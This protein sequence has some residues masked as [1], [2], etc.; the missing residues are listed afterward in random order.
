MFNLQ[1][2]WAPALAM[3]LVACAARFSAHEREGTTAGSAGES[4]GLTSAAGSSSVA[5]SGEP[6]LGG[7]NAAGAGGTGTGGGT[8]TGNGGAVSGTGGTPAGTGGGR[9]WGNGGWWSGNG[10]AGAADCATL[11]QKYQ[12]T[13]EAARACDKG[14][15]DQCSPTSVAQPVDGCGCP[16]P[17]NT[18]SAA[19]DANRKAYQAYLDA[20]CEYR[21]PICDIACPPLGTADCLQLGNSGS[22]MCLVGELL[23]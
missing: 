23:K 14:S 19:A 4:S 5:D 17:I 1:S 16:L 22:F 12:A 6:G 21:G 11:R 20:K 18:K 7:H 9:N 8:F 15:V 3:T 13:I 10:G 2:L